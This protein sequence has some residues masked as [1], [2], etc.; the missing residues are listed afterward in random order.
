M[1]EAKHTEEP[2]YYHPAQ[3][4][5]LAFGDISL[6]YCSNPADPPRIVACV[7]ALAGYNP[8]AIKGLVDAAE[9]INQ[10]ADKV[11][12]CEPRSRHE[13]GVEYYSVVARGISAKALVGLKEALAALKPEPPE[14]SG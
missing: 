10:Q 7:N 5:L 9:K 2:W 12:R 14:E 11:E 1:S 3:K 6:G 4:E 8:A 13:T